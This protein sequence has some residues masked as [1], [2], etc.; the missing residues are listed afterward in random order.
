VLGVTPGGIVSG[1]ETVLLRDLAA[2]QD[3]GWTVRLACADG[4]LVQR[5]AALGIERIAVPDLRLPPGP[6]PLAAARTVASAARAAWLLRRA[7]TPGEVIIA[8]GLNTLPVLGA[9]AR[10]RR[11]CTSRT[12]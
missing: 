1:A 8:N 7:T 10:W 6:Q 9:I 3:A 12:T 11:S 5:A 4:V 2:A